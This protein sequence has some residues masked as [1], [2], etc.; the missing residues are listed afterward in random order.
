MMY[1]TKN[2]T[3]QRHVLFEYPVP[4]EIKNE[5]YGNTARYVGDVQKIFSKTSCFGI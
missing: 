2:L 3:N 1:K 4:K 5:L